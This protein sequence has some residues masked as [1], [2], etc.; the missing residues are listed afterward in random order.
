V[1]AVAALRALPGVDPARVTALG[2]SQGGG[3]ALAVAGLVP[4]LA[5]VL[6][7]AP[8]LCHIQRA[9]DITDQEP[10][11]DVVRYLAVHREAEEQ[12]RTTLSYVDGVTFARRA[13]APVHVG[14]GLRDTVC[15]PS[16]VFAAYNQYGARVPGGADVERALHVYPFNHHEGGEAVHTAR[17][18]AWLNARMR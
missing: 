4:D 13:S 15:P 14:L 12:V 9:L 7:S 1:R 2:N 10:Y 8:F 16:T 11:G 18:L 5:A 6:V 17:Q 3:L